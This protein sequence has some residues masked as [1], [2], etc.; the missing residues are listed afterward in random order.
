MNNVVEVD[1][2]T[3][4]YGKLTVLKEVSFF[5]EAEKIYGLLG[6]NGAGKTTIMQ[7][8]TA[9]IFATGGVVKVFG[10]APH[11]NRR[12]LSQVCFIKEGQ[13]Y[14]DKFCLIDVLEVAKTLFVRWDHAY[15]LALVEDFQLP[16][17]RRIKSLSRGMLS[18]VGIVI[19]LA[20]RA[21][22][23][24]FD[25]PYLGLDAVNRVLFYDRLLEDYAE[26]PRTIVIST[27]LIDEVSRLLEHIIVIDKGEV[28]L[29]EDADAL[30][31]QACT[32]VGPEP[33]VVA[34]ATGKKIISREQFG[35]L[36]LVTVLG[37]VDASERFQ[38]EKDGLEFTSVSL[39]QLIVH[40]TNGR[41]KG[42]G[43]DAR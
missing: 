34:F 6:R 4:A 35:S 7:L 9:Q 10:D 29:N 3:K 26:H 19:G 36:A 23:T 30:R 32:V 2:L 24:L 14:P 37:Q 17:R 11:E 33:K 22:L 41:A 42:K 13:K 18:A 21:P 15:A 27:H 12:V 28:L 43:E 39:Q 5:L 40:L 1:R 31:G 25:E 20:S 8:L 16:L 38:A